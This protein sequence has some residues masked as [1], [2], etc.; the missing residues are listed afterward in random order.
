M[1]NTNGISSDNEIQT[2]LNSLAKNEADPNALGNDSEENPDQSEVFFDYTKDNSADSVGAEVQQENLNESEV[3]EIFE[4]TSADGEV[5]QHKAAE[6]TEEHTEDSADV[7]IDYQ[8]KTQNLI[9]DLL[10]YV[11]VKERDIQEKKLEEQRK[12]E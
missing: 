3:Q 12:L 10:N 5:V 11:K 7:K 4:Q 1:D 8:S 2:L 9:S 6:L